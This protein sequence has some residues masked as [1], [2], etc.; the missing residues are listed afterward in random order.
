M[1]RA[2]L[3]RILE[4]KISHDKVSAEY[5]GMPKIITR[6]SLEILLANFTALNGENKLHRINGA[7]ATGVENGALK[8]GKTTQTNLTNN[9]VTAKWTNRTLIEE[10][11]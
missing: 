2:V 8:F 6:N 1:E 9:T 10:D 7:V 4:L 5:F 3:P 11:L